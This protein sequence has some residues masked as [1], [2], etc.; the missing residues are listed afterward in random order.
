MRK[1]HIAWHRLVPVLAVSLLTAG[2]VSF[3]NA[4]SSSAHGDW[5]KTKYF[6]K[7]DGV[8]GGSTDSRHQGQIELNSYRLMEDEPEDEAPAALK[9]LGD[10]NL[11]FLADSSK[12]SPELFAKAQTG[13]TIANA[14]LS[15]RK[16][17]RSNDYLT[18]KLTDV[19]ITSYQ[20][21]GDDS[22]S[23]VDEVLMKYGTLQIEHN[24]GTP[25]KKGWNFFKK[26]EM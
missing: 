3:V 18:I 9:E 21:S 22:N 23:G 2:I 11:R 25:F 1:L 15:V 12:A 7:L 17:S 6:L 24:E 19:V 4:S 13:D 16:S 8:S 14:V 10:N 5:N 20:N 26:Q